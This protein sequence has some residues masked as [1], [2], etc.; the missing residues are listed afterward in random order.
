MLG[1]GTNPSTQTQRGLTHARAQRLIGVVWAVIH[2]D[3]LILIP[4]L[5]AEWY[6]RSLSLSLSLSRLIMRHNHVPSQSEQDWFVPINKSLDR[7][8]PS[9]SLAYD[10]AIGLLVWWL[11][12]NVSFAFHIHGDGRWPHMCQPCGLL[13]HTHTHIEKEICAYMLTPRC[14]KKSNG[15]N[16]A[17]STRDQFSW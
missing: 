12:I 15:T 9:L 14:N 7:Q 16:F 5:L 11:I 2:T 8:S 3:S 1:A 10:Q 17:C 13:P 4:C 6:A